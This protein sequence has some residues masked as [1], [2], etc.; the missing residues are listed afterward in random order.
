MRIMNQ[1]MLIHTIKSGTAANAPNTVLSRDTN[2]CVSRYMY[3]TR[4]KAIAAGIDAWNALRYFTFAFGM[5]LYIAD[6]VS[7]TTIANKSHVSKV[8]NAVSPA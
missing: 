6:R 8:L 5:N 1:P 3:C 4:V 7:E 2:T